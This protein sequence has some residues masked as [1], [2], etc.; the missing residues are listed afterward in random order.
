MDEDEEDP[1]P[2]ENDGPAPT[3]E[4]TDARPP[5]ESDDDIEMVD[6]E[7]EAQESRGPKTAA[8]DEDEDD[9]KRV[10]CRPQQTDANLSALY[11]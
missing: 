5:A 11:R 3:D 10:S 7:P 4:E 1:L 6:E 2:Q 9:G 8:Q